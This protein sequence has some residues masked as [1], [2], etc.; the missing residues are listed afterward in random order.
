M[1][2][3]ILCRRRF[4]VSS[5]GVALVPSL[6]FRWALA[7]GSTT[8]TNAM[9]EFGEPLYKAGIEHWP[10]TNPDAPKGGKIVLGDFGSFDSLNPYVL[11]G[12]W[13]PSIGLITD[14]LTVGS[15]DELSTAYPLVADWFEYPE[16][17]SW[18]VFNIRPEARYDDGVK[19]TAQDIKFAFETI[20]QHGRPFLKSF[21]EDIES[22]E[23]LSDQQIKFTMKTRDNM[24]PLMVAAGM[25]PLPRHYW[26]SR[27]ISKPTLEPPLGNSGYKITKVDPGRSI[28]YERVKDYWAADFP[29]NRGLGNFDEIR[30]DFYRDDTVQFEAF[31]AGKID[32]RGEGS[33]QR[34]VTGYDFT[35]VKEGKVVVRAVPNETPRG[36]GAY[37]FNIR[38]PQLQDVRVRRAIIH[39]YDFE[40]IQRTLLYGKYKRIKSYFPNSDFGVSGPPTPEEITILEPFKDKL[41]SEVVTQ[42][43]EPPAT[44]G[45]GNNRNNLR[46]AIALFKEAGWE[47]KGGKMVKSDTAEQFKIE[48]M[49]A[50]PETE[51]QSSPFIQNMQRG[52]LDASLRI[53]TPVEWEK[54]IDDLDFDVWSGSFNFF[55][56]PGP[57]LRSYFGSDAADVRGSANSIGIKNPVIDALIEQ[58]ISAKDLETLKATTRALDRVLLWNEYCVPRYYNHETW[59]AYWNKFS[60]PDRKPRYSVGFPGSWWMTDGMT[61]QQSPQ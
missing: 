29:V 26:E 31:K 53:V 59:I 4:L 6:T 39:L 15:D 43:Y 40:T 12:D 5:L 60:Y 30:Y 7:Q 35:P 48:I 37:F 22:C 17:K 36:M 46:K 13:P 19:T 20:K 32:Y 1:S 2:N 38:R 47:L 28:T 24:K 58:I 61:S 11:Q 21:Y 16:D 33:A 42:T 51:R 50:D 54:R 55:P 8:K 25:A 45:S 14:G 49:T 23:A 18:I 56:P 52:G 9:A 34:W 44:D 10:Y 3:P 57:E 27:D 41:P